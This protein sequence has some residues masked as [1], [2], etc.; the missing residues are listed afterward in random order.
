MEDKPLPV[1]IDQHKSSA[2]DAFLIP[3]VERYNGSLPGH[4]L[5]RKLLGR[6]MMKWRSRLR[7]TAD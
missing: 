7:G 4:Q 3:E 6:E 2:R 1:R 5:N